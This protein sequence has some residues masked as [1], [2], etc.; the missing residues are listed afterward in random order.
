MHERERERER[1]NDWNKL[2]F[3][4]LFIAMDYD[5]KS[6]IRRKSG[7]SLISTYQ[8]WP[9]DFRVR[10]HAGSHYYEGA[11]EIILENVTNV[12]FYTNCEHIN[13][14]IGFFT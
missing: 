12:T 1:E 13:R 2:E 9:T 3:Y 10:G 6:F 7:C 5:F 4:R 8:T 11:R 14:A